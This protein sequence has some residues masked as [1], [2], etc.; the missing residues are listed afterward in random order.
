MLLNRSAKREREGERG[1]ERERGREGRS[2]RPFSSPIAH[3]F[4]SPLRLQS[5]L[6]KLACYNT[7]M[8]GRLERSWLFCLHPHH[9]VV[10][11]VPMRRSAPLLVKSHKRRAP[12][13]C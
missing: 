10:R 7:E 9:I 4:L 6:Q 1:R 2:S 3:T 12:G 8:R 13:T 11:S 5:G